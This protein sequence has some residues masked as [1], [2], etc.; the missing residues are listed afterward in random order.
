MTKQFPAAMPAG[1]FRRHL[2]RLGLNLR[3][4]AHALGISY[5]HVRALAAGRDP[6]TPRVAADLR[7]LS[8]NDAMEARMQLW[9]QEG[10]DGA[11]EQRALHPAREA[12]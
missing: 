1:E 11:Q 10:Y 12:G 8:L 2:V 3:Q 4:G 7:S 9:E 6:I 5:D